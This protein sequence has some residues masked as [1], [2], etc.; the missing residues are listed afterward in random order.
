MSVSIQIIGME[1]AQAVITG[2]AKTRPQPLLKIMADTVKAQ[3]VR[4][5]RQTKTDPNGKAWKPLAATTVARK[6]NG[7]ILVKTGKLASSISTTVHAKHATVGTDVKYGKFHQYGGKS[8][9][10][11][12]QR[13][14]LG[15]SS[16][17]LT[18]LEHVVNS[19]IARSLG[20]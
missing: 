18:E 6:G 7:D 12:P 20:I 19:F 15:V 9:T 1:R 10:R 17:D 13:Q 11:P 14:F 5:I 3:T 4:R 16:T 2:L 8:D